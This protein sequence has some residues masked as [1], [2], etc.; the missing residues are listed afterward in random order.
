M[1]EFMV[2]CLGAAFGSFL[3]MFFYQIDKIC[4][5]DDE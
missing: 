4:E 2:F 1:S 5:V 3:T